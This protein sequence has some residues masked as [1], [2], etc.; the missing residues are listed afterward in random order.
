M[1]VHR[2]AWV[3]PVVSP[4][5]PNGWVAIDMGRIV[6][7]GRPTESPPLSQQAAS[8]ADVTRPGAPRL[9]ILPGLV[10]AHVHLELSWMRGVVRSA[11]SMPA[12][13]ASLIAVRRSAPD[14]PDGPIHAAI[15]E[16]RA[17]G[18]A[19]VGDVTNTLASAEPLA[20]SPLFANVFFEQLG[21]TAVEPET[22]VADA[23]RRLE[24]LETH[25]RLRC[26]VVPHAPYSVSPALLRAIGEMAGSRVIS[27]HLGESA[28]EVEFLRD[29]TGAWRALLQ[30]LGVWSDSWAAPRC[31]PVEYIARAGLLHDRLV[32]VHG[33]QLTDEELDR[34]AAAGA[35]LVTCPRSNLWTGAGRPPVERF[36]RSGVKVAVGTDS[37]ASV[38]DLNVFGELAALHAAA[39]AVPASQL[40]ASATQAGAEA[41]GF[42]SEL[43]TLEPGKRAE[44]LAVRLPANVADVEEYLVSGV[45]PE[46][47]TWL[48]CE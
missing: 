6:A 1:I 34:L 13:A 11:S 12:W 16:A 5:V 46:D 30:H 31:G 19:L 27:I 37:L 14:Q 10:N 9:V 7:V 15:E 40:I 17:T 24:P 44:L 48:S 42:G 28:E 22:L 20:G 35:T 2:A 21:F 36:Y 47:V 32:A 8:A 33:V 29:G 3:L 25:P 43:G 18:T 45:A 38:D 4:P 41:L 23:Q 26:S 39:P